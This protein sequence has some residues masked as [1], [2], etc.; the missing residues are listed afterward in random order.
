MV[1]LEQKLEAALFFAGG[2]MSATDLSGV[3]GVEEQQVSAAAVTLANNLAGRGVELLA[4]ENEY[5]L[6]TSPEVSDV[7]AAMRKEEHTKELGKASA[8]TLAVVVYRGPVSRSELEEIRGVNCAHALRELSIR[9][10][11]ARKEPLRSQDPVRYVATPVLLEH[12]GVTD[13]TDMPGYTA[14]RDEIARY[15]ASE[16]AQVH[17][18]TDTPEV[19]LS[20]EEE[21]RTLAMQAALNEPP[22]QGMENAVH[23]SIGDV[24]FVTEQQPVSETDTA[25]IAHTGDTKNVRDSE[26]RVESRELGVG[27]I[28]NTRVLATPEQESAISAEVQKVDD[29]TLVRDVVHARIRALE[30]G[31]VTGA[32]NTHPVDN[33]APVIPERRD[34]IDVSKGETK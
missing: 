15:E 7:V 32:K 31:G 19:A 29:A 1:T 4:V 13:L 33:A 26:E 21:S 22:P 20:E 23:D 17:V 34:D 30:T 10:L 5:E 3:L 24:S 25:V 6:V 2:P 18:S 28:E 8:E 11:V 14:V 9:G 12:L 16:E 27:V